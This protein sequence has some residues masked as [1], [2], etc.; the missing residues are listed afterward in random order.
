MHVI[1]IGKGLENLPFG[2][3]QQF[4]KQTLGKPDE[5]EETPSLNDEPLSEVWHYDNAEL[6]VLFDYFDKTWELVSLGTTSMDATLNGVKLVGL[7]LKKVLELIK[8]LGLGKYHVEELT[9]GEDGDDKIISF[10]DTGIDLWFEDDV[11]IEIQWS[12]TEEE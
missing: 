9:S 6:S 2:V 5:V 7:K 10:E 8:P 4:V 3:D 1:L 12:P 11:L